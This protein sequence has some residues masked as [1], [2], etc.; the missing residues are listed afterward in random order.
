M[1]LR[2]RF[3]SVVIVGMTMALGRVDQ[4]LAQAGRAQADD[5]ARFDARLNAWADMETGTPGERTAARAALSALDSLVLH[6]LDARAAPAA[7]NRALAALHGYEGATEGEGTQLGRVAFYSVLP[8]ELPSYYAHPLAIGRDT[9]VLG[10]F[11]LPGQGPARLSVYARRGRRWTR[12]ALADRP[13][14]LSAYAL[15]MG[16]DALGLVTMESFTGGDRVDGFVRLWRLDRSGALRLQE[17]GRGRM[18]DW[19]AKPSRTSVAIAYDSFPAAVEA[20]VLGTR[21]R[22]QVTYAVRGGR[23]AA[24]TVALNPWMH[25]VE[26]FFS[27]ARHGRRT[28]AR[29][30]VRGSDALF[31]RV[32]RLRESTLAEGG[33]GPRGEGWVSFDTNPRSRVVVRK[34][35]DSRWRITGLVPD[36]GK[37]ASP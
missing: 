17:A 15:P 21:L 26:R 32:A 36:P 28:Q 2:S 7:V 22:S 13:Y 18:V 1:R 27:L 37:P 8:R 20:P 25:T 4:S 31:A 30:L 33:N 9:V 3:A 23:I 34:G 5:A 12:T 16:G 29:G 10:I 24:D 11:A 14:P 6:R 19:D 35:T